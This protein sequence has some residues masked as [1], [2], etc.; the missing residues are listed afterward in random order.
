MECENVVITVSA[1]MDVYNKVNPV[2]WSDN[3]N[4]KVKFDELVRAREV[5]LP[6]ADADGTPAGPQ[7]VTQELCRA[8][9]VLGVSCGV[10]LPSLDKA[11]KARLLRMSADGYCG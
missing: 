5:L 7:S 8:R 9:T 6:R 2:C 1:N 3:A 4:A 11:F 10:D